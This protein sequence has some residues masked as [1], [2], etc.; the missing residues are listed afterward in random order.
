MSD[1]TIFLSHIHEESDMALALKQEIEDEFAGFVDV[2]VSSDGISIP[3]GTNFLTRIQDSLIEC[4]GA[5]Y[6]ISP[7]SV[8]RNWINFELG[9]VWV[10]NVASVKVGNPDIPTI[11]FCHSGMTPSAL[12]MPLNNLNSIQANQPGQLEAAFRSIQSAVGIKARKLKT[13][14]VELA[15]AVESFERLY[16]IGA[17][18]KEFLTLLGHDIEKIIKHC[19]GLPKGS[20]TTVIRAGFIETSVIQKLR[21]FE[22]ESLS[23]FIQLEIDK[24][25]TS[26]M[27]TG[28]VN[29]AKVSITLSVSLVLEFKDELRR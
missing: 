12:P 8:K 24:P 21:Q 4:V 23:E 7:T 11:P 17:N 1:K 26:F 27:S 18:L 14:F 15:N 22:A 2:F 28:A 10:R 9:A 19:E 25:G 5:V 3:S 20:N 13:N 6:L 16:M 29:G